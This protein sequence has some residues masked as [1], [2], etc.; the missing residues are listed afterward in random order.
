MLIS[1]L[2]FHTRLRRSILALREAAHGT[3]EIRSRDGYQSP[4]VRDGPLAG[5]YAGMTPD[6]SEKGQ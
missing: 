4:V 6:I 2:T 5:R 3:M 1:L